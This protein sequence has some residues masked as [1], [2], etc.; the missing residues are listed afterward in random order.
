MDPAK[1]SK[2]LQIDRNKVQFFDNAI[3]EDNED[4]PLTNET[5]PEKNCNLCGLYIFYIIYALYEPKPFH[6]TGNTNRNEVYYFDHGNCEYLSTTD[7]P[8]HLKTDQFAQQTIDCATRF[9]AE[10]YGSIHIGI[11]FVVAFLLQTYRFILYSLV[12]PATVGCLQ[13]TSDYLMKPLMA[14]LFNGFIQ[15][16]IR[17]LQNVFAAICDMSTPIANMIGNFLR[18]IGDI[19]QSLRLVHVQNCNCAKQD[20]NKEKITV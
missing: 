8:P 5:H 10:F 17:F 14:V 9:W 6:V 12:R 3:T 16:P 19:I 20:E 7:R 13:T 11:A 1:K 15:P 2:P 18:P 4:V